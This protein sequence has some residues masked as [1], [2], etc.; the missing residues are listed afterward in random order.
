MKI[1]KMLLKVKF[2]E[3]NKER[4]LHIAKIANIAL[5]NQHKLHKL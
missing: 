5:H 2:C 4:N 3:V 1:L